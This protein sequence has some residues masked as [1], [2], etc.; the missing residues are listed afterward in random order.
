MWQISVPGQVPQLSVPPQPL[1]GLPHVSPSELQ[2]LG[3]QPHWLAVPPPPQLCGEAQVPQLRVPPQPLPIVPQFA[4]A[5]A[6]VVQT[7]HTP[8]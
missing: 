7:V 6:Q 2:V 5:A 1:D 4:P 3:V 8:W